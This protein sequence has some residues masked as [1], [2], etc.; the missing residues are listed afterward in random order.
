MKDFISDIKFRSD[1]L[2]IIDRG[3]SSCYPKELFN[4]LDRG[5]CNISETQRFLIAMYRK[6]IEAEIM[7]N[8]TIVRLKT[9]DMAK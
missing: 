6:L 3:T 8:D 4:F 7:F 1:A 9:R 5:H 2:K